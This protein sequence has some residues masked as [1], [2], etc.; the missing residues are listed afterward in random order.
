MQTQQDI[1]YNK[2]TKRFENR[3]IYNIYESKLKVG[4]R[5]FFE[6]MYK[7]TRRQPS[8]LL[9][10]PALRDLPAKCKQ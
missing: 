7:T 5:G 6:Q 9:L 10:Y 3:L 8:Y 4:I 2:I 1:L